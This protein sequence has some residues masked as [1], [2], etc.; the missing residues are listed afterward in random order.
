ME[1]SGVVRRLAA[2]LW[3][4]ALAGCSANESQPSA[5]AETG[6]SH[7]PASV[8]GT[9]PV[10][11]AE[12]AVA[13]T[14]ALRPGEYADV[15]TNDLVLRSEPEVSDESEI[16]PDELNA[17][18][19]VY[20]AAGPVEADG[21]RWFLVMAFDENGSQPILS[22]WAAA[23]GKD[24]EVWLQARPAP[25]G[26]E[27]EV[28]ETDPPAALSPRSSA[29]G[30][31]GLLYFF[32]SAQGTDPQAS[33]WTFDPATLEWR[34]LPPMP[35]ARSS[36]TVAVDGERFY[37]IGGV[38]G[39]STSSEDQ[40]VTEIFDATT[41]EWRS[42][43]PASMSPAFH[44]E[45]TSIAW[46]GQVWLF[47]S[48]GIYRYS[49]EQDTWT[50][51]SNGAG[52]AWDVT[53]L[54]SGEMLILDYQGPITPFDPGTGSI[55]EAIQPRGVTR[56]GAALAAEPSGSLFVIGGSLVPGLGATCTGY[57]YF[58]GLGPAQLVEA[59]DPESG[60]WSTVPPLEV[61]VD[62]PAAFATDEGVVVVGRTGGQASEVVVQRRPVE[63]PIAGGDALVAADQE[64]ESPGG[65]G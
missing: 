44:G 36:P 21:Y 43:A 65:C 16:F 4:A 23:E 26:S 27:W 63:A 25:V 64:L 28:L 2:L 1:G 29:M 17:P 57:R 41:G 32:G 24:G 39:S 45:I 33:A 5:D 47:T 3:I 7:P 40:S 54:P 59:Y 18:M 50:R 15:V 35:T 56:F 37:V 46:D 20:V 22:G 60:E 51:Q 38:V 6:P 34:E 31:D 48:R 9:E 10:S 52:I 19:S 8:P 49:P 30:A 13:R 55:G 12:S 61:G 53:E 14:D 58:E 42:A 11:P 62:A